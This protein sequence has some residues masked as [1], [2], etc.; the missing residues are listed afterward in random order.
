VRRDWRTGASR[1][2]KKKR[3][4][5]K[6]SQGDHFPERGGHSD[7]WHEKIKYIFIKCQIADEMGPIH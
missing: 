3:S 1:R 2:K 7:N 5:R 6:E 4:V